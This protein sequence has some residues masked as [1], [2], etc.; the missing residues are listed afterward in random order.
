MTSKISLE[1]AR[2]YRIERLTGGVMGHSAGTQPRA[3]ISIK[4][5]QCVQFTPALRSALRGSLLK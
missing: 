5:I 3:K 4:A 1:V 2:V